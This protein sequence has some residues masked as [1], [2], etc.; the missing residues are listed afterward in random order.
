M[1]PDNLPSL[2]SS[3]GQ[4]ARSDQRELTRIER[5]AS[6]EVAVV[7]ARAVVT[8]ER[9][10]AN[11]RAVEDVALDAMQAGTSVARHAVA[12]ANAC[13]VAEPTLRAIMEQTGLALGRIVGDTARDL[14]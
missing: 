4:I 8:A 11:V 14:R 9:G 2:L 10:R 7:R 6:R 5:G 13:P 1:P 3:V 12:L